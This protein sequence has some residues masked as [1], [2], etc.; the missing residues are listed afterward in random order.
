VIVASHQ[1]FTKDGLYYARM[2]LKRSYALGLLVRGRVPDGMF[3]STEPAFHSMRRQ[4][5]G[6]RTLWIVGG[7]P[8]PT[9]QEPD[10]PARVERLEA[11]ARARFD[12]ESVAYRW[13]TQ[14][15][16]TP[17][18]LPYVGPL[19]SAA[20]HVFV[21]TGFGGWGMSNGTAAA[22]LLADL[23]LGRPNGWSALYD[24]A[25]EGTLAK[26]AAVLRDTATQI[27]DVEGGYQPKGPPPD[28]DL[29]R[30]EARIVQWG[31]DKYAM[32]CDETGRTHRVSAACTH[33]GCVVQWNGA[34][35]SWDCPCHGSRFDP[36]G[37][38]LHGP[39]TKPL[40]REDE[41]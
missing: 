6:D 18:G 35:T 22:M 14:D 20:K 40:L 37:R 41:T 1:P 27:K 30:G 29:A 15:N 33:L 10:T 21:A 3:I 4:P 28:G 24:P 23:V 31:Y 13:S 2:T 12:V 16:V 32:Y 5:L 39:A 11:W 19:T 9:G 26:A 34:E 36:D 17:D 25:R 38:I 7:E 8:H